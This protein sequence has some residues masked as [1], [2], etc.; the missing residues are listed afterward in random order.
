[1]VRGY[2][3]CA[4]LRRLV[5][6]RVSLSG[7]MRK[8]VN[9]AWPPTNHWL[10]GVYPLFF[11]FVCFTLQKKKVLFNQNKDH[12]GFISKKWRHKKNPEIS[13]PPSCGGGNLQCGDQ[14][15]WKQR[16]V[17]AGAGMKGWNW[18]MIFGKRFLFQGYQIHFWGFIVLCQISRAHI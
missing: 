15:L 13:G 1:M 6:K 5:R 17:D 8:L 2:W 3:W 12:L 10:I 16:G 9:Q 18:N 11:W 4:N 14:C 7:D